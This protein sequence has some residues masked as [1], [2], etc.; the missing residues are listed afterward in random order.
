M[1]T[2]LKHSCLL[3]IMKRTKAKLSITIENFKISQVELPKVWLKSE[4]HTSQNDFN[5][6]Y[7]FRI[8]IQNATAFG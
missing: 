4:N 2:W 1:K 7:N 6:I 5:F 3:K 8:Y